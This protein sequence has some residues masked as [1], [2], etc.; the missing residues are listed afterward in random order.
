M[1]CRQ[2]VRASSVLLTVTVERAVALVM[3]AVG[4]FIR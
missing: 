2:V 3:G 4:A 1:M